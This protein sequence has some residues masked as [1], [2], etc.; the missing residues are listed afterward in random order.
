MHWID[1]DS[2]PEIAGTLE[3]FVLNPHGEVDGFVMSG[4]AQATILVHTPPHMADEITGHIKPGD[5]VSVR[6][7]RARGTELLAAV[8]ISS[9]SGRKIVDQG[10]HEHNEE[11]TRRKKPDHKKMSAHGK[12]RLS[13][14]GPKGE[15][16]G[17][18]LKDGTVIR[19]GPKEAEKAAKLL[20][21]GAE[22]AVA[23]EGLETE[24][25]RVVHAKEIGSRP[26]D[27]HPVKPEKPKGKKDEPDHEA[28]A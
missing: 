28:R 9:P 4:Q 21:P 14:F 6:G 11:S 25:G 15:L 10:P 7:V 13:L 22:L 20:E 26:G 24:H 8:A 27:L 12:V 23:G 19:V 1:P 3:R 16:R 5:A 2:L 17:A 18:L